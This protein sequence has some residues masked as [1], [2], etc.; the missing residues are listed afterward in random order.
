MSKNVS[1]S[2]LFQKCALI[3]FVY[4]FHRDARTQEKAKTNQQRERNMG[5]Q[6]P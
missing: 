2:K 5:K 4:I 6:A 1:L 3:T